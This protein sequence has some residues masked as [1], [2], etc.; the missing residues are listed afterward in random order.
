MLLSALVASLAATIQPPSIPPAPDPWPTPDQAC[1]LMQ[2][3]ARGIA[4]RASRRGARVTATEQ[5]VDCEARTVTRVYA[6][7]SRTVRLAESAQR[8]AD[9]FACNNPR[10]Q[11]MYERD[12]WSFT[13]EFRGP[14]VRPATASAQIRCP[15]L[16]LGSYRSP[17]P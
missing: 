7:E 3:E 1:S 10:N 9:R 16:A 4:R 5:R 11:I 13:V 12:G 15:P 6:V 2:T 14:G 17:S 8:S